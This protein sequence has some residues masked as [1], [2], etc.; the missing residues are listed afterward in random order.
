VIPRARTR[1]GA[2]TLGPRPQ[3]PAPGPA[4]AGGADRRRSRVRPG[5]DRGGSRRW[6]DL[7]PSPSRDRGRSSPRAGSAPPQ[8]GPTQRR[9][10]GSPDRDR[11][12]HPGRVACGRRALRCR[13][14]SAALGTASD[15]GAAWHQIH[16]ILEPVGGSVSST[17]RRRRP[18]PPAGGALPL[19]RSRTPLARLAASPGVALG[20]WKR[21]EG[22]PPAVRAEPGR[23]GVRRNETSERSPG[24]DGP[25]SLPPSP[26]GRGPPCREAQRQWQGAIR[27]RGRAGGEAA[28]HDLLPGGT[29]DGV[30]RLAR[31]RRLAPRVG[32]RS[33]QIGP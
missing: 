13:P 23:T 16:R 7:H 11:R 15:R 17:R 28:A 30:R 3:L 6:I 9:G 26:A 8:G 12:R 25:S 14:V 29:A 19:P 21:I 10:D 22:E 24:E 32:A 4:V 33:A 20:R 5:G 27:R 31:A 18:R 1:C 2:S